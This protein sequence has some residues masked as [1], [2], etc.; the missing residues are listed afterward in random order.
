MS[1]HDAIRAIFNAIRCQPKYVLDADIAKCFDKIDHNK[2]LAK[3]ETYPTLSRQIK[4]WLKSGVVDKSWS[5]TEEG[6]PQGGVV[7]PLLANI[8]LHGTEL[9][10][11]K[12]ART[13][14]GR[15]DNNEKS[16]SLI[17]YADD[18]VGCDLKGAR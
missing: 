4:A 15:K 5:A 10:I 6:T 9:E 14:K 3:L 18:F 16:I 7:S 11:K 2:L 17:R 1:C 13:W 12:F 8:A